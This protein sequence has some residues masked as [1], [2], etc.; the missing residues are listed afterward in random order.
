MGGSATLSIPAAAL[1]GNT[2]EVRSSA[3]TLRL[4]LPIQH[5]DM[6]LTD[7]AGTEMLTLAGVAQSAS[8]TVAAP[9]RQV[10]VRGTLDASHQFAHGGS[11]QVL[12]KTVQIA[13]A[14]LDASG[15]RGG[16]NIY[17]GGDYQGQ[18]ELLTARKTL[19]DAASVL[20]ADGLAGSDGGRIIVWADGD[21]RF[22]GQ[23]SATGSS[24]GFVEI[25]GAEQLG[26]SGHADVSATAPGGSDGTVLFDPRDVSI[27]AGGAGADDGEIGDG[28]IN[29]ADG[30]NADFQIGATTLQ[31]ITGAVIVE[32]RRNITIA[33]GVSLNF[34]TSNNPITFT[35]DADEDGDG[36]FTMNSGDTI[37]T[38]G[39]DLTITGASVTAGT[40]STTSGT[41]GGAVTITSSTGTISVNDINTSG[42]AGSTGGTI[43]MM[44]DTGGINANFLVTSG[45]AGSN[46]NDITLMAGGPVTL[47][48]NVSA[49][50]VTSG[51]ID[52]QSDN[53]ISLV[54]IQNSATMGDS[55][56]VN[57]RATL[58]VT[59]SGIISTQASMGQGGDIRVE[60]TNSTI[61]L[62]I[63]QATGQT[64]GSAN[65][66]GAGNV[67]V[68]SFV[69]QGNAG[70]GGDFTVVSKVGTI[71]T[72]GANVS[73]TE[74][75]GNITLDATGTIVIGLFL[76]TSG[77]AGGTGGAV[78]I[79]TL[80]NLA[81]DGINT[82]GNSIDT[83]DSVAGD[84]GAITI[85]VSSTAFDVGNDAA[86]SGTEGDLVSSAATVMSTT[87]STPFS[88]ANITIT[89]N[90]TRDLE[91]QDAESD[92]IAV[93]GTFDFGTTTEG[94]PLE[95]TF[96]VQNLG[97]TPLTLDEPIS[98]PAG[99][100]LLDSFGSTTLAPQ[101]EVGDAT[102][103]R[104]Q[105]D[106]MAVGTPGGVLSFGT[107]DADKNPYT[108]AISGTV[109]PGTVTIYLPFI[110]R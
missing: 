32:A 37:T 12:G 21:T 49:S 13:G 98:V 99:F 15:A 47:T 108:F 39:R 89:P 107:N 61:A 85:R 62:S 29:A 93:A 86:P 31:S 78:D 101:N 105:L 34:T 46:G 106:A 52:I 64:G 73:S 84:G 72:D 67:D 4:A 30:D 87:I 36:A 82:D 109:D 42:A 9:T 7:S 40:M 51:N 24:G 70:A 104:V 54:Q 25:S 76:D 103:F 19:I 50:G 59:V 83:R 14:T 2:L 35:A 18:G 74:M 95:A 6:T 96:T 44:S 102:T 22:A 57:I 71:T 92:A 11:I 69:S 16:G 20:R 66:I 53:S 43:T 1:T 88:D 80:G 91:V 26:F 28:T 38:N 94:T 110:G 97:T 23:V 56:D 17:V 3:Y 60:S 75:G 79:T 100:T 41:D 45:A 58:D 68:S 48:G 8:I 63:L 33:S 90:A 65:I 81:I 77:A 27:V 5:I 55:G 10:V